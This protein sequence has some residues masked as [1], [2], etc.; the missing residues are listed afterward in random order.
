MAGAIP[1]KGRILTLTGTS[2]QKERTLTMA[3]SFSG[4]RAGGIYNAL[5]FG[6]VSPKQR[7]LNDGRYDSPEGTHPNDGSGH[8]G[9]SGGRDHNATCFGTISWK[10][11]TLN[12][13]RYDSPA[14]RPRSLQEIET[15]LNFRE[16]IKFLAFLEGPGCLSP[17]SPRPAMCFTGST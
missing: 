10:E 9:R 13:D 14:P 15:C 16:K 1:Q 4:G 3:T 2:P 17:P 7:N 6:T 11:R 5:S 12:D 8:F